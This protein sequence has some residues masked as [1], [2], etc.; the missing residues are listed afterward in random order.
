[1][2]KIKPFGPESKKIWEKAAEKY[3][4]N[5]HKFEI[6]IDPSVVIAL[7]TGWTIL[8][9]TKAFKEGALLPLMDILEDNNH[10]TKLNLAS[11]GTHDASFRS[12][13]ANDHPNPNPNPIPNSHQIP[14]ILRYA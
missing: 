5:C 6:S 10:I 1:M 8:Q 12:N 14:D 2:D 11:L 13:R 9:P 7:Q 3:I 4:K